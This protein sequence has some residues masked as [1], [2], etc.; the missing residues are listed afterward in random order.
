VAPAQDSSG[1]PIRDG[2]EIVEMRTRTSRTFRAGGGYRSE[3]ATGSMHHRD[4]QGRWQPIDTTLVASGA[5]WRTKANNAAVELPSSLRDPVVIDKEGARLSFRLRGASGAAPRVAG[6]AADYAEALPGVD[7]AYQSGPDALKETFTLKRPGTATTFTFDVATSTGLRL[8]QRGN[9][10]VVLDAAGNEVFSLAPPFMDDAGGAHSDAVAMRVS[11]DGSTITLEADRT[12]L[13]HPLRQ[14]PVVVDPYT[15]INP[16]PDCHIS[17]SAPTTAQCTA[18]TLKVGYD[19]ISAKH[20]ALLMFPE[21]ASTI[22]QDAIVQDVVMHLSELSSTTGLGVNATAHKLTRTW[23]S[24]ATWNTF[25]GTT[26]W[27]AAGGDFGGAEGP[28]HH[29]GDGAS[30]HEWYLRDLVAGWVDGTAPNQG[31]LLKTDE[32]AVANVVT[33]ASNEHATSA[34]RP[35][36]SARWEDRLGLTQGMSYDR[37]KV[38]DRTTVHVNLGNGN[39]VVEA[40]D[41]QMRGTGLDATFTRYFNSRMGNGLENGLN[42]TSDGGMS[43]HL[44]VLGDRFVQFNAPSFSQDV[45]R[46]NGTN[47]DPPPGV[48]AKLEPNLDGTDTYR[49]TWNK[50]KERWVFKTFVG[51]EEHTLWKKTDRNNNTITYNYDANGEWDSI[52]DTQGRTITIGHDANN[53]INSVT[54]HTGRTWTYAYDNSVGIKRV[55]SYTNPLNQRTDYEYDATG[56]ISRIKNVT[57]NRSV[58]LGYDAT[59]R[60]ATFTQVTDNV[61]DTGPTTTYA[62]DVNWLTPNQA[63]LETDTAGWNQGT[64]SSITRSTAQA[65]DGTAGLAATA[66]GASMAVHTDHATMPATAGKTYS[67]TLASRAATAADPVAAQ[68]RWVNSS[69]A[70]ISTTTGT[71]ATDT[72][73]GWTTV[74]AS[75]IAPAGTAFV[76]LGATWT[77]TTSGDV[78]Y[79]DKAGLLSGRRTHWSPG[80]GRALPS[81]CA[82]LLANRVTDPRGNATVNCYDT[83]A[84]VSV[85]MDALGHLRSKEYNNNDDPTSFSG[86]TA[87]AVHTLNYDS[88][89]NLTSMTAPPSAGGQTGATTTFHY[90]G[91]GLVHQPDSRTDDGGNC[92]AFTYDTVGNMTDV[93]DGLTPNVNGD[94]AGQTG[95]VHFKNDYN[96]DGTLEWQQAPG[97]NCTPVAPNPKVRCTTYTYTYAAATPGPPVLERIVITHPSPLGAET[98]DFD[99]LGRPVTVTDGRGT[100]TRT[101]YDVLDRVTQVRYDNTTTCAS[102]STC[103]TWTYD[104]DGNVTQRVDNTGTTTFTYDLARRMTKKATPDTTSHCSGQGGI[105]FGWDASGNM[106]TMCDAGGTV[107]YQ[108]NEVNKLCWQLVGTSA[109]TCASAPAGSVTFAYDNDDRR[110]STTYPTSPAVVM[111][112][113]YLPSGQ[114]KKIEATRTV[115]GV[116]TVLSRRS[117]TYTVGTKDTLLRR[118]ETDGVASKVVAYTYDAS[119]R[120]TRAQ[121]TSGGTD[122]HQYGYDANGNRTS[123]T[124]NG[125]TTTTYGFN[126]ANQLTSGAP[127]TPTFDGAGNET[128]GPDNRTAAYNSKG[129]TSS[130]TPSGGTALNFTYADADS[131]ERTAAGATTYADTPLGI[132]MSRTGGTNTYYTR[133]DDGTLV[134]QRIGATTYYYVFDGLGSVLHLVDTSGNVAATY[135]YDP[136][137]GTTATGTAAAG[138]PFRFASGHLD[139]TGLYK[140]GTRYYDAAYG[141]W[142]QR[143][144]IA[145]DIGIPGTVNR[146]AYVG[147]DPVNDTDPSGRLSRGTRCGLLVG[148]TFVG[149]TGFFIGGVLSGGLIAAFGGGVLAAGST[150]AY[151]REKCDKTWV[152]DVANYFFQ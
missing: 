98:I 107:A 71:A 80:A 21:F 90:P 46:K 14:W 113:E 68:L 103:T 35:I 17:S 81:K 86:D 83:K 8:E 55:S 149:G 13:A 124:V 119:N 59:G 74:T 25:D 91:T 110:T 15:N 43:V 24:A 92:R 58:K 88:N 104:A 37:F 5:K 125:G 23:T 53:N 102:T 85:T 31:I 28:A 42:W 39:V 78:H 151:H 20:R 75:G 26:A 148:A 50:S 19:G 62:Y 6:T 137:G 114:V 139:S 45:F 49:V 67:G 145:G 127:T 38:D 32:G 140:F 3:F 106:S 147:C 133:D 10:A 126:E 136:Y 101:T 121:T 89:K 22:R 146:Y 97:G 73:T 72:T 29:V 41:L 118:T 134:S 93:H 117:Y 108:Y 27:T 120:L 4:R 144:P 7:V 52:T 95:T 34:D 77:G 54:D 84:R 130:I 129:Q 94:C 96:T 18:T 87:S 40:R 51:P 61:N 122:D 44:D 11:P 48:D 2:E 123:L 150:V 56:R 57:D 143:D 99:T 30:R 16:N 33:F 9:A 116:T 128:K 142:T 132:G 138:N 60:L 141:R 135:G 105:T 64:S 69:G 100:V 112:A 109:N 111:A 70:L 152:R 115:S 82:G 1:I 66:G 12:W 65:S 47:W 79:V 131:T 63:S 36:L 76:S